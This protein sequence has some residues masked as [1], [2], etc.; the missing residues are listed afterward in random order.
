MQRVRMDID[1]R[2]VAKDK[3]QL[4]SEL[5]L[6]RSHNSRGLAGIR[7]FVVAILH[8]G[9]RSCG[10]SLTVVSFTDRDRKTCSLCHALFSFARYLLLGQAPAGVVVG[11]LDNLQDVLQ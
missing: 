5:L 10:R 6:N 11:L 7:A 2:E 4:V 3:A 1:E 8:Q 9:D